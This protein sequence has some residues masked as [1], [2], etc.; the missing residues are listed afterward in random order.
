MA[1][2]SGNSRA[3]KR[4]LFGPGPTQVAESV[5]Q[6]MTNNVVGHL[7]PSFFEVVNDL[8][9]GLRPAFGTSN[10][11]TLAIS[12]TGSSGM[13]TAVANFVEPGVKFGVFAAGY[14]ADR[15]SA[16]AR[17]HGATVGPTHQP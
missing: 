3:P 12:G 9:A 17:R 4:W 15:I 10:G 13:E 14:F 16:I 2:N 7:D 8:R 11:M 1:Q 5:Y 6:A